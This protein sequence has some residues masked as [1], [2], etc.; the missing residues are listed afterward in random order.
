M[1]RSINTVLGRTDRPVQPKFAAADFAE[2]YNAK[3]EKIR[4]DTVS[5][6]PPSYTEIKCEWLSEF[7][8]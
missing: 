6:P 7:K 1:W 8:P 3:V 4:G 5:A 2:F